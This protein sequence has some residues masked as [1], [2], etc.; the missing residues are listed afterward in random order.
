[1]TLGE[2]LPRATEGSSNGINASVARLRAALAQQRACLSQRCAD[3]ILRFRAEAT[4]GLLTA[5][6]RQQTD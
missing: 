4:S 3:R 6:V 2:K 5:T 1:M